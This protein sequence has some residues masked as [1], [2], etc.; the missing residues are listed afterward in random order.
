MKQKGFTLIEI[1]VTVSIIALLTS[2][3]LVS[4]ASFNRQARDAKRKADIEQIRGALELYRSDEGTYPL[5]ADFLFGSSLTEGTNTYLSKIPQDPQNSSSG[6]KYYYT[7]DGT[8]YTVA[9][10]LESSVV[11]CSDDNCGSPTA[12]HC[13]YCLG[14][15]GQQ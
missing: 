15:Y 8:D 10:A 12:I 3:G 2:I 4:Y 6:R 14:P 7:S 1:L 5:T 11:S 9:A 13:N